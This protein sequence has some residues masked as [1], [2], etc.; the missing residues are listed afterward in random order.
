KPGL[1]LVAL[2]KTS[3]TSFAETNLKD[4]YEHQQAKLTDKDPRGPITVAATSDANLGEL[5]WGKGNARLV[6]FSSTDFANNKY[7]GDFFNRDLFVNS[8]DWLAGQENAVSIRPATMRSGRFLLTSA[9]FFIIFALSVLLLPEALLVA[10]T[11]V[12]SVRRN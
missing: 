5:G 2:A 6:V 8:V 3:A 10:G 1:A 11:I 12:W 4:L 9:Q 7:I